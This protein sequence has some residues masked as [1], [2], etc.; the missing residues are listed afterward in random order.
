MK[1][2]SGAYVAEH[3][4]VPL[5]DCVQADGRDLND[6]NATAVTQAAKGAHQDLQFSVWQI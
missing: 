5:A 1:A 3:R 4:G 2:L 6:Q